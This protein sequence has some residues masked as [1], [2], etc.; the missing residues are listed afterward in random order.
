M[1]SGPQ[2]LAPK[3]LEPRRCQLGVAHRVLDI[4]V[5]EIG[6]QGPRV[7]PLV[8]QRIA[9]GMPQHV[10]VRLEAKLGLSP[11][12]LDHAG[13]PGGAEGRA[14]LRREYEWRLGLLLALEP[15]Q[16]AQ[17]V[18]EDGMGAGSALLDPADVQV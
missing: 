17:L 5:A 13:E 4:P 9:A 8:R 7:V 11:G 16:G 3:I 14:A 10:R 6:L 12:P 2:L 1:G 18:A 15:P